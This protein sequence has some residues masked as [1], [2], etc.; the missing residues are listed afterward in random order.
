MYSKQ[1]LPPLSLPPLP[2]RK[3]IQSTV[4]PLPSPPNIRRKFLPPLQTRRIEKQQVQLRYTP[5]PSMIRRIQTIIQRAKRDPSVQL[6][7]TQDTKGFHY[8]HLKGYPISI[9]TI[10]GTEEPLI[11]EPNEN[12]MKEYRRSTL[13]DPFRNEEMLPLKTKKTMKRKQDPS[14]LKDVLVK[15]FQTAQQTNRSRRFRNAAIL[16]KTLNFKNTPIQ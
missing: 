2:P 16:P 12:F 3:N 9:R 11:E 7:A 13:N 1:S 5:T 8:I 4:I 15:S 6:H 14:L 10:L